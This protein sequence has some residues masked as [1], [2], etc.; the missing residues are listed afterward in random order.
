MCRS[1]DLNCDLGEGVGDDEALMPLIT[2]A[3]IACG[4]HAGNEAVMRA[5]VRLARR[6][7]VAVGAHPGFVD[8]EHFGRREL[9][10]S[11]AEITTLVRA[12]VEA[13]QMIAKDEG[14]LITHVKPHGALYN[15][16][17][18]D[19]GAAE[20]IAEAVAGVDANL[21]LYGLA[22]SE[23]IK[24]GR[25]R[26]LRVASEV[27]ADRTYQADGALTD[28]SR[29]DALIKDE[30]AAIAQVLGMI[31]EGRVRTI[32]GTE[33]AIVADTI[34]LHGDAAGA[35]EFARGVRAALDRE[36]VRLVNPAGA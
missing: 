31:R 26:G 30:A 32:D 34:C 27:F 6:H 23:L 21:W 25:A 11:A 29:T 8:R 33:V 1:I 19:A 4:A 36:G 3:N 14:V 15:L 13:L 5:T 12:Q 28:R 18:R 24:R 16:A 35:V 9:V 10:L 17:A 7:G 22:G 20:A 2:S